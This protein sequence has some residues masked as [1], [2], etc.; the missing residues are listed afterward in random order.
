MNRRILASILLGAMVLS[1]LSG[2]KREEDS[3]TLDY[4]LGVQQGQMD[5][6]NASDDP[7]EDQ[8]TQNSG[9]SDSSA[10]KEDQDQNSGSG[11]SNT[12]AGDQDTDEP[13]AD[14]SADQNQNK[15]SGGSGQES[16]SEGLKETFDSGKPISVSAGE[17][18]WFGPASTAQKEQLTFTDKSGK[19]TKVTIDQLQKV[20][21]F[22]NGYVIYAYKATAAGSVAVQTPDTYKDLFLASKDAMDMNAYFAYW[23]SIKDRNLYVS[24][25]D[26]TNKQIGTDGKLKSSDQ[27]GSTHAISVKQGDTLTIAPVS[28]GTLVQGCAYDANMKSIGVFNGYEMKEAFAFPQ[29]MRAYTYTVPAGVSFVRFN[30]PEEA[31]DTFLVAKNKEFDQSYYTR[32]TKVAAD[33]VGDPLFEKECLFVGD[34]LC[35][36]SQD[37]KV[38]GL[39][40]WARRVKELSGAISTNAGR[41]GAA[42]SNVRMSEDNGD[43]FQMIY[44]QLKR[45][46][47][48]YDYILIEG[49]TND[50]WETAPIGTVTE[51]FDPTEFDLS[52]YAGGLEMTI[53]TAIK[54]YGDTAAIGYMMAY[55]MPRNKKGVVATKMN[56]YYTVGKEIC[57]KWNITYFD[58]Y[59]HTEINKKLDPQG[60][61]HVPDGT[62]ADA[63]GYDILGPY[64]TDYMRSMTPATQKVRNA[65]AAK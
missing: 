60:T 7:A 32:I 18:V 48:A 28:A 14:A 20:D 40:G 3:V 25:L 38:D 51:G 29:G 57:E 19:A 39:R 12:L 26:K 45:Y 56:D 10:G 5:D 41:G 21:T 49:G 62:H 16:S 50:A 43:G 61:E 27:G 13:S 52:T 35:S 11:Q 30:V 54:E 59:N 17:T 63:S 44:N 8:G 47:K 22:N 31:R 64:I 2:C 58:M 4:G 1:M 9:K 36:A 23:D 37:D 65:L 34:S 42:L 46:P 6:D 15:P 55:Q 24:T 53:Y 33:D